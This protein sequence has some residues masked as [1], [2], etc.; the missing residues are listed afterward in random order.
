VKLLTSCYKVTP[1][2]ITDMLFY[3]RDQN[4]LAI[5]GEDGSIKIL[6]FNQGFKKKKTLK[7]HKSLHRTE[8]L[9]ISFSENGAYLASV[10]SDRTIYILNC[11][12]N[13]T[14][15]RQF[16]DLVNYS[17]ISISLSA[18]GRYIGLL[19]VKTGAVDIYDIE[20][21]EFFSRIGGDTAASHDS[22]LDTEKLNRIVFS[23]GGQ[24]MASIYGRCGLKVF[25]L[26]DFSES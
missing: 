16:E 18:F 5:G 25:K 24:Y 4:I 17:P 6:E 14:L 21:E 22:L 19:D 26:K 11:D 15:W 2:N 1:A 23:N 9:Q 13:W 20:D 7:H 8:V 3:P 12:T 10:S